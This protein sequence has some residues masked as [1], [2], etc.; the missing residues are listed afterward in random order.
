MSSLLASN[1]QPMYYQLKQL[2]IDQIQNRELKAND[3]LPTESEYCRKYGISKAPVRQALSE[4]EAENYI[5]KIRGKGSFVLSGYIKQKGDCLRS[6]SEDIIAMGHKP[7]ARLIEQKYVKADK[8]TAKCLNIEDGDE[9]LK[10]VRLRY[11][12]DE[13]YSINYSYF[14]EARF[15]KIGE[16]DFSAV[17]IM[18]EIQ[19]RFHSDVTNATVVLEAVATTSEMA[20][21][22]E[23]K[24][25]SPLLQMNR[26]TYFRI[27]QIEQPLEFVRV[28]F[29]PDKYKFEVNLTK[30]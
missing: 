29:V 3:M 2:I 27:N 30:K 10:V 19:D 18:K 21:Y 5:Y 16:V 22:L 7:G 12:D 24:V 17:S 4:L 14:S 26:T 11:I 23:R 1:H 8:E 9:V 25:G 6:F 13:I 20:K 15:P 28:Y